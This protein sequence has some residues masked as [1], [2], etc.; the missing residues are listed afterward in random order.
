MVFAFCKRNRKAYI[1]I[2][3]HVLWCKCFWHI[4]TGLYRAF[5]YLSHMLTYQT[6]PNVYILVRVFINTTYLYAFCVRA[7]NTLVNLRIC[8]DSPSISISNVIPCAGLLYSGGY[9]PYTQKR[10]S[11]E[12]HGPLKL[13]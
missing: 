13:K 7:A 1:F 6:G 2:H 5:W 8:T 4:Y 3:C 10:S 12:R 11:C 9:V